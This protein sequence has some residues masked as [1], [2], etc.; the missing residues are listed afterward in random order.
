[1][2]K[3]S[4]SGTLLRRKSGSYEAS[5][6]SSKSLSESDKRIRKTGNRETEAPENSRNVKGGFDGEPFFG[7]TY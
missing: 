2:M 1:M 7:K 5:P 3:S 6:E 4:P